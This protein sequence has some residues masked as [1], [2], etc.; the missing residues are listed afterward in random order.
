MYQ[1][2]Q[3]GG[4]SIFY[5]PCM[6]DYSKD[7]FTLVA[8]EDGQFKI[9]AQGCGASPMD[10]HYY[11]IDNGQTWT[12]LPANTYTPTI[13]AGNK[14][15]WKNNMPTENMVGTFETTGSFDVEG[16]IMSLVY[17]DNFEGQTSLEGYTTLFEYLFY[18]SKVQ[19]AENLILPATTLTH[20]CYLEMFESCRSLTTAPALPATTLAE[21]CYAAMFNECT[22]LT[23]AP[24]LPAT[25][26]AL[27]CYENMFKGCTG[28][29]TAPSVL[30]ATTLAE[31]C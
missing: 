16:N 5:N 7:Y 22:S 2:V 12:E 18:G 20:A 26:L 27:R 10:S 4:G 1:S 29:T 6:H 28:L 17:G 15:L 14:V 13:T 11:S 25:V 31:S 8:L 9:T 3:G 30:P 24:E 21:Y 19:S 23:T